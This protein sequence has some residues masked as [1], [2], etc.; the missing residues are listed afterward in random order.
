MTAITAPRRA[1]AR[2]RSR[3]VD[4]RARYFNWF[5]LSVLVVF[6]AIWLIPLL[7]ALD[8]S[9]KPD[10]VIAAH[11]TASETATPTWLCAARAAR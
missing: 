8:T 1:N 10:A 6:A 4:W 9:L 11:P 7:W 5:C 3:T 2:A